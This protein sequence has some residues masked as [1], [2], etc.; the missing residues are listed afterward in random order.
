MRRF[1]P[2]LGVVLAAVLATGAAAQLFQREVP[3]TKAEMSLSFAP[4]VKKT[5]P[6]VVNVY[7]ANRQSQ[8]RHPMFDDPFFSQLFGR[9]PQGRMQQSVGS[10]VLVSSDG[11]VITNQHVIDGMTELKV[12]LADRR[13]FEAEV[14][15]RDPKSDLAVLKI[16]T[17]TKESF[18][19][20]ELGNSDDLQ[21]GDLVLAIGNPFGVG[22]TVTQGIISALARTH[23]DVA[24]YQFFIQTDAAINPGNSGGALVDVQGRL[25]GINSAIYSKSG[26]SH[27]IGFAIPANM[28]RVVMDSA[29]AGG[30]LVQRP[31]YGA[32]MQPVTAE[33][34]ENLG[35]ARP[36]GALISSVV[37]DS[38]AAASGL[39]AGDVIT[40]VDGAAVDDPD[41]FGFRFATKGISGNTSITIVRGGR[42]LVLPTRL[43][44]APETKPRE[45]LKIGGRS[46]FT[47]IIAVN[48]SPAVAEELSM[49][50]DADGVVV[51]DVDAG[52]PA[53]EFGFQKGDIILA[54]NGSRVTSPKVLDDLVRGRNYNWRVSINRGGQV[55]NT[56][57]GG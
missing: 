45:T 5:A 24:D 32:R 51:S 4:L 26:G 40:A 41:S 23:V 1:A 17:R 55:I 8:G 54:I 18:P 28:V 37:P 3:Q 44:A 57:I 30:K 33:I 48:L 22:Q 50:F 12:A 38:P 11:I 46:P 15:L 7:G 29:R 52:S 47:G 10:G 56:I 13:E 25:V 19:A 53:Q 31:W 21:V 27:G 35:L 36:A 20:L 14:L 49:N 9:L 34:G 42:T 39:K 16:K 2:V 43:M 6:A